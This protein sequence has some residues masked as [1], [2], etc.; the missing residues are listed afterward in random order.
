[1]N[2]KSTKSDEWL[3]AHADD[4][5]EMSGDAPGTPHSMHE[6]KRSILQKL[7]LRMRRQ[8]ESAPALGKECL[9]RQLFSQDGN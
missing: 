9:E 5:I 2:S 7:Q 3:L 4:A 6:V 1:M 8:S